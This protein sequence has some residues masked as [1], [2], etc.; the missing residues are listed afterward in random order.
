MI[1]PEAILHLIMLFCSSLKHKT[2]SGENILSI[3]YGFTSVFGHLIYNVVVVGNTQRRTI[4][5]FYC[6]EMYENDNDKNNNENIK[7]N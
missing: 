7:N 6:I 5:L 1:K 3:C 4:L 2:I